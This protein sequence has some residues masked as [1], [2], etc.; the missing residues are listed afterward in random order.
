[1]LKNIIFADLKQSEYEE[2]MKCGKAYEKSYPADAVIFNMGSVVRE[3]GIVLSGSVNIENIDL[4]GNRL[5]LHNLGKDQIFAETY[6]LCGAAMMVNVRAAEASRILFIDA[7]YL[8]SSKNKARS[9]YTKL[10]YNFLR[11]SAGKNLAWSGRIFC[12]TSKGVRSR[13]MSYLSAEAL[14]SGSDEITIPFS[15]QELAD[16]LNVERSAL[17]KELG[18]MQKEGL[19][20]FKKNHFKLL[21]IK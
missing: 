9:W 14:K 5:I 4:W 18:R 2:I 6:A 7:E 20:S 8:F 13:V 3:F 11:L 17:S 19:L 21:N 12:I 10:L 16:Y 15:R 1:M